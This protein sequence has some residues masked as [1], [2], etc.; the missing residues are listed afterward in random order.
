MMTTLT[1]VQKIQESLAHDLWV[2]VGLLLLGLLCLGAFVAGLGLVLVYVERKVAAHFQ[3]RLGPMRVGW[4]GV[5]QTVADGI[6]LLLKEDIVPLQA[7]KMLHVLA[8]FLC[9]LATLLAIVMIPFSPIVQLADCNICIL[10]ISAVSGLGILGILLGGWSSNN[11]WSLLGAMRAG[12]QMISYE[13]SATLAALVIVMF[14]GSLR[15]SQ[16]VLSQHSGWWIWRAPGVG[17][18]AFLIFLIASIA[19]IN[20]TPFDLPEGESEITGGFHTEY[21]GLR[22][23]FF[24]LSEFINMFVVSAIG[25]TLFFGGWMPFHIGN[26]QAFNN[27][28][29]VLPALFWFLV[30]TGTLI[31]F[32]MWF[33]WTFP[34]LRVD[35]LMRLEW[36]V[37]LP[38]GF[39]N[40]FL[41]SFMI[42]GRLYFFPI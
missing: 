25:V 39:V 40:L 36:K 11:K 41:A 5:L 16:I 18:I 19:E 27:I 38:I 12:A 6:K 14:S 10:Y 22:F 13:I 35:Q 34:R 26:W 4:H 32:I 28:M 31:F 1:L 21:S 42:L 20:R 15:L 3:C 23:A 17:L 37:L 29:D 8:P 30:K 2:S 9:F 7:D 33:R 24:F